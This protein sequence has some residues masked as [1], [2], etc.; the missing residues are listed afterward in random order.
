MWKTL[1]SVCATVAMEI[2]YSQPSRQL[3]KMT[4]RAHQANRGGQGG[5]LTVGRKFFICEYNWLEKDMT[6]I[7]AP[8]IATAYQSR[9][10]HTH[11]PQTSAAVPSDSCPPRLEWEHCNTRPLPGSA[12]CTWKTTKYNTEG[13]KRRH[14]E[15]YASTHHSPRYSPIGFPLYLLQHCIYVAMITV[16]C[17]VNFSSTYLAFDFFD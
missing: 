12:A 4:G 5:H 15:T 6:Q 1:Q 13:L 9:T 16:P 7:E 17:F 14:V 11:K 10:R 8:K 3:L 2:Q